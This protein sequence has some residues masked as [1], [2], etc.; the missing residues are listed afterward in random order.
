MVKQPHGNPSPDEDMLY[1]A[2]G[3]MAV[4]RDCFEFVNGSLCK[5]VV[6]LSWGENPDPM[7]R[8]GIPNKLLQKILREL[9]VEVFGFF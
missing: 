9:K 3:V 7:A 5:L 1:G 6:N 2:E 8:D 4:T